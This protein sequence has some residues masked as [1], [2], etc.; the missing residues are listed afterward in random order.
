MPDARVALFVDVHL[1]GVTVTFGTVK[2]ASMK[3]RD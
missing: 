2:E 3:S 1:G